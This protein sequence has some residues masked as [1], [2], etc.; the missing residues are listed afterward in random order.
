VDGR[1]AL[2]PEP[3]ASALGTFGRRVAM[4]LL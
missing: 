4:T 2:E 1:A 3:K